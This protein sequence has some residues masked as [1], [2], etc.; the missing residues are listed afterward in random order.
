MK[1]TPEIDQKRKGVIACKECCVVS[2]PK[3]QYEKVAE[4][5]NKGQYV[6]SWGTITLCDECMA[7][8]WTDDPAEIVKALNDD[9]N[10]SV[11]I[12][13]PYDK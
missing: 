13:S 5:I 9:P 11:G 3:Y 12:K 4:G 2:D 1:D 10:F 6:Y 8:G 7:Q